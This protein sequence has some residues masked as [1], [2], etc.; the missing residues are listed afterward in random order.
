MWLEEEKSIEEKLKVIHQFDIAGI[1]EW[2][3]GLEKQT[4]WDV[5]LKYVN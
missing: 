5:I 4:I 3:L 2:K 1:A